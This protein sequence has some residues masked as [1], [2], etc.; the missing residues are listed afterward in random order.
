ML[1]PATM[2]NCTGEAGTYNPLPWPLPRGAVEGKSYGDAVSHHVGR[3]ESTYMRVVR[4]RRHG[5]Y[6]EAEEGQAYTSVQV[7]A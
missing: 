1:R 6:E 7:S 2:A 3:P 5:P 4:I